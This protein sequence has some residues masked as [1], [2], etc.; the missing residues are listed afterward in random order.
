MFTPMQHGPTRVIA[1]GSNLFSQLNSLQRLNST[2]TKPYTIEDAA[3]LV[4][5]STYQTIYRTTSGEIKVL[6]ESGHL[7]EGLIAGKSA[8]KLTFVGQDVIEAVMDGDGRRSWFLDYNT[9]R[10][11]EVEGG[12]KTAVSDG[13]GRC[14]AIDQEGA[15]YLF[16]STRFFRAATGDSDSAKALRKVTMFNGHAYDEAKNSLLPTTVELPKFK[17]ISAGSAHFVLLA[18]GSKLECPV[19]IYGD[20]RF[21]AVPLTPFSNTTFVGTLSSKPSPSAQPTDVPYLMPVPHFSPLEG[22]PDPISDIVTGSRHTIVRTIF[23]DLYGWG[24]NEHS[25]LLPLNLPPKQK[26]VGWENN[27]IPEPA[28]MDV[29][30]PPGPNETQTFAFRNVAAA[31]GRS[32][33]LIKAGELAVAGSNEFNTLGLAGEGELKGLKERDRKGERSFSQIKREFECVDGMQLHPDFKECNE[34]GERGKVMV[35]DVHATSLAT[36][37]TLAD[38][39][40]GS[41]EIRGRGVYVMD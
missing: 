21:G 2:F 23:G 13:R 29:H 17:A 14:M 37:L 1:Y 11:S 31:G 8:S 19:W 32:F 5:V 4:A 10:V 28:I 18:A 27:I 35:V 40:P 41:D 24:W 12:W 30:L 26:K 9:G 34:N 25:P 39:L 22:F 33:A 15:V 3:S 7:L 38:R 16:D 20:A 36:F 6:G